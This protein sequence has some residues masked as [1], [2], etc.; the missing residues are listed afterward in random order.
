MPYQL[1]MM[2]CSRHNLFVVMSC[3]LVLWSQ[4]GMASDPLDS[5]VTGTPPV[6]THHSGVFNGKK[7]D[8]SA[9]VQETFL[10]WNNKLSSGASVITISYIQQNQKDAD[11]RP[12][13]FIFNGGPGASSSPLHMHA[14]GP[15]SLANNP[16][17]DDP[18]II[19][20]NA[21]SPLDVADLVFIDP[22]GT[23]YTTSED[24]VTAKA[25][26]DVEQD[27]RSVIAIIRDWLIKYQRPHAPVYLCGQS[28]G[29]I[30]AVEIVG[31][32]PDLPLEGVMLFSA[33]LDRGAEAIVA[34]NEVSYFLSL[35]T[36]ASVA[37]YHGK[38]IWEEKSLTECYQEAIK[39]VQNEYAPSL[40]KG[41]AL[42]NTEQEL[43]AEKL[44]GITGL[45]KKQILEK[46]LRISTEDYQVML[47]ADKGMRLGLLD[48][49]VTT[50]SKPTSSSPSPYNDPSFKLT[51]PAQKVSPISR[52]FR[53]SL[54]VHRP[55]NYNGLNL[56]ANFNWKWT[57]TNGVA[58]YFT[59]A[60]M[61]AAAMS[62][63][64]KLKLLVAGGY[65]DM[66]TP[67]YATTYALDHV[68]APADRITY[69]NFP[70]GHDVFDTP[71]DLETLTKKIREFVVSVR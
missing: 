42:K 32:A 31:L 3:F 35:P 51:R 10:S 67:L 34:G 19:V 22:V 18:Q 48:A 68:G 24:S 41:S 27:A 39:F 38:S 9:E 26:W 43:L 71:E 17:V 59:V 2:K 7:I 44:S 28:Y 54:N 47:F 57:A 40:L 6:V 13:I 33:V 25:Y 60:P 49:R 37:W 5:I 12:V 66:A 16:K 52:Y 65:Y 63:H 8:Y 53:D 69:M 61:I 21:F 14:L 11:S 62:Q 58:E 29:T 55:G 56:K 36:L 30:R 15:Y 23:G 46:N 64:P 50:T 4:N 20:N 70:S 1:D 45:N